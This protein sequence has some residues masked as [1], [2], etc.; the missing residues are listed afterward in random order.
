MRLSVLAP[1]GRVRLSAPPKVTLEALTA[2]ALTRIDWIRRHQARIRE[3]SERESATPGD[4]SADSVLLWGERLP[5]RTEEGRGRARLESGPPAVVVTLPR[6]LGGPR[7]VSAAIERWRRDILKEAA[8]ALFRK[9]EPLMMVRVGRLFLQRMKSRWGT[10]NPRTR[11]IRLN[12]ELTKKPPACLE[13]VVVHEM[14]HL[15]EAS[16]NRRFQM[17]MTQYLPDWK[18]RRKDLR[19]PDTRFSR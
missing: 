9:W 8:E 16:H 3:L 1:D 14:V 7:R 6:G 18:E 4:G 10:C 19:L 2:F 13:Y 12:T 5:L 11:A 15:L 17:L